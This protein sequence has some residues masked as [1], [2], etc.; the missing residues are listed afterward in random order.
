MDVETSPESSLG[1]KATPLNK[2]FSIWRDVLIDQELTEGMKSSVSLT[3]VNGGQRVT[4]KSKKKKRTNKDVVIER[5]VETFVIPRDCLK[6]KPKYDREGHKE[7]RP[8][9]KK[10]TK[11]IKKPVKDI[12]RKSEG[13]S[14][15]K[16]KKLKKQAMT[17]SVVIEIATALKEPRVDLIMKSIT[18]LGEPMV[19]R[20][21]AQTLDV[22]SA[23]GL[24]TSNQSRKRSP[25]GVF[26]HLIKNDSSVSKSMTNRIFGDDIKLRTKNKKGNKKQK[27]KLESLA[28]V[29][30]SF[31]MKP[32]VNEVVSPVEKT[33]LSE[34]CLQT[35]KAAFS[36]SSKS[37]QVKIVDTQKNI[38]LSDAAKKP[39]LVKTMG[40][41]LDE[42]E[43]DMI[44]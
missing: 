11:K 6:Q 4:R 10:S 27:A 13:L 37:P 26:F 35:W 3:N 23:G 28:D 17:N 42:L 9:N 25:G 1:V 2:R 14:Q 43:A 33:P 8:G 21:F 29:M 36:G 34:K 19:K 16:K 39:D 20:I 22:E 40:E 41:L 31:S 12:L 7:P 18:V 44:E 38:V 32:Q 15:S 5:D 30:S 24:K